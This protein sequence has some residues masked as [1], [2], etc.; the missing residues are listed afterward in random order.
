[1]NTNQAKIINLFPIPLFS[2]QIPEK[3]SSILSFFESL[4]LDPRVDT[5]NYGEKSKNTYILDEPE[6]ADLKK[7]ILDLVKQYSDLLEYDYDSYKFSQ[8]WLTYKKPGQQ[9]QLHNHPNSL[10]SGVF[11]FGEIDEKTPSI[12][13]HKIPTTDSVPFIAPKYSRGK[14]PWNYHAFPIHPTPGMLLLFP[15]SV[16]HSVPLNNTDK[17][18][19]SLAFNVVPTEGFGE[20]ITLTKLK[21]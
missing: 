20:E 3:F 16:L 17:V 1:M 14:N 19:C 11:Y 5:G 7:Y 12:V 6:C 18:R 13:F 9:H 4:E 15:S 2:I 10:I 8:S 21:F